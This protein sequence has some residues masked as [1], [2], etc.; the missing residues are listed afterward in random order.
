MK[1]TWRKYRTKGSMT[2]EATFLFPMIFS[3]FNEVD[4]KYYISDANIDIV[5]NN[6]G[7]AVITEKMRYV[8]NTTI[9]TIYKTANYVN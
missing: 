1:R 3:G 8:P 4:Y 7:T 2:V 6:D 9:K 5:I